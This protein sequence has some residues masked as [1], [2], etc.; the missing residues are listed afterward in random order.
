MIKLGRCTVSGLEST[1]KREQQEKTSLST[2][3]SGVIHYA[4]YFKT[5]VTSV[6][7]FG[8]RTM[9]R[10]SVL[11]RGHNWGSGGRGRVHVHKKVRGTGGPL[12]ACG[13][14]V[15][16]FPK[17]GGLKNESTFKSSERHLHCCPLSE[18]VFVVSK[19]CTSLLFPLGDLQNIPK[20]WYKY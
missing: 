12:C 6:S 3:H 7:Y 20:R 10:R 4:L 13:T 5:H 18:V 11:V 14:L 17:G 16:D 2:K 9:S 1:L 15:R 8:P 19:P